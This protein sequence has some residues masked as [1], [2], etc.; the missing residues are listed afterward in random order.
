MAREPFRKVQS[1]VLKARPVHDSKNRSAL[2][3]TKSFRKSRVQNEDYYSGK[4][5]LCAG[6]ELDLCILA[7]RACWRSLAMSF[8]RG[9]KAPAIRCDDLGHMHI[10]LE[11]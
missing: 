1:L 5:T 8:S 10:P 6:A 3:Q 7:S 9:K 2:K 4:A 11:S